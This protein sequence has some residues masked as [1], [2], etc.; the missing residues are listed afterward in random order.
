MILFY[1]KNTKSFSICTLQI[2]P[3]PLGNFITLLSSIQSISF[4]GIAISLN[5]NLT[6]TGW[7]SFLSLRFC[8]TWIPLGHTVLE[9]RNLYKKCSPSQQ[10]IFFKTFSLILTFSSYKVQISYLIKYNLTY[11]IINVLKFTI[12]CS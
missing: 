8:R 5:I 11:L 9:L 4:K 10:N 6:F 3:T 1:S 12:R 7:D 2:C